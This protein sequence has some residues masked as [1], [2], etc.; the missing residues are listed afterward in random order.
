MSAY[1][2][3]VSIA[4]SWN[5]LSGLTFLHRLSPPLF[6]DYRRFT[7][8]NVEFT[9]YETRELSLGRTYKSF[10]LPSCVWIFEALSS[11]EF[12][13]LMTTFVTS[14]REEGPVTIRT[15]NTT[16][17]SWQNYNARILKPGQED[18][19]RMWNGYEYRDVRLEFYDLEL[20]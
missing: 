3:R 10:G 18:I 9:P 17:N 6:E 19:T 4:A 7:A 13:Y 1:A 11:D 20:I 5:N 15:L 16:T 12:Q 14:S 2:K 8:K